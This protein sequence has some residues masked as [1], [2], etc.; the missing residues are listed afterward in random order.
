ME[1]EIKKCKKCGKLLL[2]FNKIGYCLNHRYLF[3]K[4]KD[5]IKKKRAERKAKHLCYDCGNKV[6]PIY[7]VRCKCCNHKKVT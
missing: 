6:E 5:A 3:E 1:D 2:S 4:Y 7:P